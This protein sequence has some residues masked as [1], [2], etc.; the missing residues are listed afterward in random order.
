MLMLLRSMGPQVIA[1]D[2]IGR[3]EEIQAITAIVN[4]GVKLLCTIHGN[5]LDDF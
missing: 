3:I 2:E 1:V 5:S 4:S